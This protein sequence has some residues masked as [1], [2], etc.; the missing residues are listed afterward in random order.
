MRNQEILS[1]E[2]KNK[3]VIRRW[4]D[5]MYANRHWEMMS[6]LAGPLYIRHDSTGTYTVTI[7]EHMKTIK[8]LYGGT[9]KIQGSEEGEY[10]LIAEGD[11]VCMLSWFKG[12]RKGGEGDLDLYN[13]VQLFRL[14]GGKIVETWFPGFVKNVEWFR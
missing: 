4:V 14:E 11:K 9:E 2:E 12:Y 8:D 13:S 10:E 3:A 6:E 5:E 1:T 7:E